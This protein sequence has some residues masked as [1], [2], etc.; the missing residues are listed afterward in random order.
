MSASVRQAELLG[1]T[2]APSL[3]SY[4]R[5]PRHGED[6]RAVL[7]REPC[8]CGGTVVQM[9]GEGPADAVARHNADPRHGDWRLRP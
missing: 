1:V 2:L 4:R 3:G 9:C 6:L 8:A 7:R 5:L